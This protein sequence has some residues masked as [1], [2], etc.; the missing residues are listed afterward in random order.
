MQKHDWLI[1]KDF[2]SYCLL[3]C[4]KCRLR[5]TVGL[6]KSVSVDGCEAVEVKDD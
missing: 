4:Q 2:D 3:R 5:F 1:E 6:G